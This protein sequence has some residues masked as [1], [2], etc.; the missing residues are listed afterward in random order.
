MM[1]TGKA[2][3][4]ATLGDSLLELVKK[5][6]VEPREA[7]LKAVNKAELKGLLERAGIA[8]DPAA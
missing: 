5:K 1:Q 4:M 3:G 6:V 7:W 2:A 8:F